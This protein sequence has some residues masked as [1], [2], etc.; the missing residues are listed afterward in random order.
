MLYLDTTLPTK[1]ILHLGWINTRNP[2]EARLLLSITAESIT[3]ER[4]NRYFNCTDKKMGPRVEISRSN[5]TLRTSIPRSRNGAMAF[6][7][8]RVSVMKT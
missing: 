6:S 4:I 7:D 1:L 8:A 3:S 5:Y 2:A